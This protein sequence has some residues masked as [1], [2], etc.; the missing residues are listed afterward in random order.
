MMRLTEH[1]ISTL[2]TH[3]GALFT[4][5]WTLELF[6]SRADD[7]ARGGD[8]DLLF[9]F[10]HESAWKE[11]LGLKSAFLARVKDPLGEQ[12]ID[13]VMTTPP[14]AASDPF[15]QSLG[16]RRCRLGTSEGA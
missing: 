14:R 11:A 2:L 12:K 16:D 7:N 10:E 9:T 13:L 8:I 1:E 15:I 5:P 3:A 6:G 4:G